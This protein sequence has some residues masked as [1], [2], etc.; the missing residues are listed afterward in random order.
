MNIENKKL[1]Q[2]LTL[3]CQNYNLLQ[4]TLVDL[5]SQT[6]KKDNGDHE[7]PKKRKACFDAM[8]CN[9]SQRKSEHSCIS[10]Y[11]DSFKEARLLNCKPKVSNILIRTEN[12][13]AKL[14]RML[15]L[16][17]FLITTTTSTLSVGLAFMGSG[18]IHM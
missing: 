5:F 2:T 11:E 12:F 1:T 13:D 15:G 7:N 14:V 10:S 9:Q 8:D 18:K 6:P 17:I 16:T 4:S 3:M